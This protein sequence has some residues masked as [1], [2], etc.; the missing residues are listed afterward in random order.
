MTTRKAPFD[1]NEERENI[2]RRRIMDAKDATEDRLQAPFD[3]IN[4]DCLLRIL[5]YLPV[6]GLNNVTMCDSRFCQA[7]N[8]DSLDQTRDRDHYDF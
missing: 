3:S 5:T 1:A 8:H 4:D 7:R 6:D 2:K